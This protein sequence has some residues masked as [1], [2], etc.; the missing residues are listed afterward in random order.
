MSKKLIVF[1]D[2]MI[3]KLK[4]ADAK[5]VRGEGN[6]FTIRV[7][8]SGVKT[9]L[10]IYAI[11][12]KRREMNLGSYPDVTLETARGK[13]EDAKKKVKNGIDPVAEKEQA[14]EDRR[15]AST[16]A[17]LIDKY[18]E[19]YAKRFKKSWK[20][21]KW[22]L[23]KEVLPV[24]GKRKAED[25]RKRDVLELLEKI[26]TRPAPVMANNTFKIIRKMF[27]WSVEQDILTASP[28]FMVKLPSPKI[29][30]DRVLSADE[31]KTLWDALDSAYISDAGIRA[32]KLVLITAQ[33]PGEIS[34]IHTSEI[35]GDWWTVPAERSKNGKAHRV[36]L[37]TTAQEIIKQAIER[38][39]QNRKI[40]ADKEYNGYIFPCPHI[41][42]EKPME[43]HALSRALMKNFSFP[44]TDAKGNQL[45]D[46]DG[47]PA[48]ENRLKIDHFTPHDLRRTAA[49]FMAQSGEMD[50]VIDA[51]LNHAKQGI[52]KV[53]NQ[54]RYDKEKQ[55]ALVAWENKL[56]I[57][58]AGDKVVDL[59]QKRNERK[60]A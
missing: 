56:K 18:I 49:T 30:R 14:V 12:G 11:D 51:V 45:F 32:L 29:E 54:Y 5:Y 48:T 27:N 15:N 59:E 28:A 1:T 22:I 46:K 31:I 3:K 24:W 38:V 43:R 13:F 6:G 25:I 40:P 37:T 7:M 42:K 4:P 23:D 36:F 8:P 50:E 58:L 17:D 47:K 44:L 60:A 41:K 53:Y 20:D 33:R 26:V 19:R 35:D 2:T 52:I 16:V 57:I 10:Y 21:D 55:A 34:G 39:K 9:W